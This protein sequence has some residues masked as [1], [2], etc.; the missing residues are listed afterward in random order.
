[1]IRLKQ[2]NGIPTSFSFAIGSDIIKYYRGNGDGWWFG[3]DASSQKYLLSNPPNQH[4]SLVYDGV[5][6]TYTITFA[7]GTKRVF[8]GTGYL[9]ALIDRNN[10]QVAIAYD[11]SGRIATVTDAASR[12]VTFAYTNTSFP[13]LATSATD[14]AGN[15]ANY[16]YDTSGRLSRVAY[17]DASQYN[18]MYDS[19]D[20]IT[21]VTDSQSKIVESHSYDTSRRGLTSQ[22]A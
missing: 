16:T 2:W 8:S 19:N 21:S 14:A 3:W 1:M 17:P 5:A 10:N 12:A 7:D 4:A 20:L 22:R 18:F 11:T 15:I 9:T 13:T 6:S